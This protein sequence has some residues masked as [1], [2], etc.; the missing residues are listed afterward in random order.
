MMGTNIYISIMK[1]DNNIGSAIKRAVER[2][3]DKSQ[4]LPKRKEHWK[5]GDESS[6]LTDAHA[7]TNEFL[8]HSMTFDDDDNDDDND[9][10][11]LITLGNTQLFYP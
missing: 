11:C 9:D 6:V 10:E 7:V 5:Q 3:I 1:I 2:I 8:I 4:S